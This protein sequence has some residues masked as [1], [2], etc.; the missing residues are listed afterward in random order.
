MIAEH[1]STD[2][3]TWSVEVPDEVD[4]G[5]E[6]TFTC[7]V[8]L[9]PELADTGIVVSIRDSDDEEV[10]TAELTQI[11]DDI[12]STGNVTLTA[13]LTMG[14]QVWRAL[15]IQD[16]AC[17]PISTTFSFIV[18]AHSTRLNVWNLPSAIDAGEPF[19]FKVGV[20]CSSGCNLA[21]KEVGVF[22]GEGKQVAART[23][24]GEVWPGTSALYY[25]EIEAKAPSVPGD[26]KWKIEI[27]A[28]IAEAPHAQGAVDFPVKVMEAPDCEVTVKVV[29]AENRAPIKG[30]RVVMHP[31]RALADED[32][33]AKLKVVKG[34]YKLLVSGTKYVASSQTIEVRDH[35]T[36]RAGLRLEPIIDPASYYV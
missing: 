22:D 16:D 26:Y 25:A 2:Y 34:T 18:K 12:H 6:F 35:T 31:Y 36:I 21:G 5:S 10:A 28:S 29:D 32:G 7:Q 3:G 14:E 13:P 30:A 20:K 19:T 11:E 17:E 24:G 4:A 8:V 33:V 9:P 1:E 15:I 27:P 23:L